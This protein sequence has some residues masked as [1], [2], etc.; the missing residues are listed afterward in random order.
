MQEVKMF[1]DLYDWMVINWLYFSS[2]S[3]I[4]F[5]ILL[6]LRKFKNVKH[7]K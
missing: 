1:N 3:L 2:S 4:V 6:Y 7:E 5:I